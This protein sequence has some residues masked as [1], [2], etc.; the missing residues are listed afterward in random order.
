MNYLM[1]GTHHF[2]FSFDFANSNV[3]DEHLNKMNP[4]HVPDVVRLLSASSL[5]YSPGGPISFSSLFRVVRH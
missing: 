4:H 3:N 5:V 2:S 1:N